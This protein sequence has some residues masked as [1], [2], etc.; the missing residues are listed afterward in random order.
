MG[1]GFGFGIPGIGMLLFWGLIVFLV[2]WL[3]RAAA[4]SRRDRDGGS[5][6]REILD[7][8]FARDE[9]DRAEYEEKRRLLG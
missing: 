1:S 3:V 2:V 9:I 6:A 7:E 8:R 5:R 4:G